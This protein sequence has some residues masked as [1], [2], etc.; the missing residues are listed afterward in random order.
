M[1][2]ITEIADIMAGIVILNNFLHKKLN[3]TDL[4]VTRLMNYQ[5]YTIFGNEIFVVK[6]T[7]KM[8][9]GAN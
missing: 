9:E 8:F 3:N 7:K 6:F 4:V 5:V 1:T 2:K